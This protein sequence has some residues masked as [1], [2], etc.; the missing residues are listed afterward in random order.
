MQ[1][2]RNNN[3]TEEKET[4]L[5]QQFASKYVPYWPLFLVAIII[6]IAIAYIYLRY[7]TP[8]YQ[9]SATLII[10]DE[11][12]GNE[13]SKIVESL[14]Q[15]SSKKIVENEIEIIQSRKLMEDVIKKLGLYAP[16]YE[17]GD[18]HDVLAYTK[19]P[20]SIIALYPDSLS[21]VESINLNYNLNNQEVILDHRY[22]Y[23]IDTLVNTP[24]GKLKFVRNQYYTSDSA[25]KQFYFSLTKPKDLVPSFLEGLMV[26]PA[27]KL[28]SIVDLSYRDASP[29]RAE[30]ILNQLIDSYQQSANQEKDALAQNTLAFVNKRLA[31][32]SESLD[33][34]EKNVQ[35]FKSGN[36]AVDIS[37]QG[38]LFLQNVSTNDQKLG[39][40]TTQL[41]VLDKVDE[42]VKSNKNSKSGI[43]PSTLGVEDPML[44]QLIDKLYASELE[45]DDLSKTVGENNPR[46]VTIADKINKL[47]PSIISNINSMRQS[48]LASKKNIESTNANYNS[49]LQRVPEKEKELLDI[50][51]EQQIKTNLYAFL[52]QKKEESQIAAASSV[53]NSRV[54]DYAQSSPF[55]VSPRRNLIYIISIL[56]L[57]GLAGAFI[58]IKEFLTGKVLYRHEIESLTSIPI[59]GEIAFDKSKSNIVIEKGTRSFVAEEFR[60]LRISLSFL[61]IGPS[62]KKILVT[63][64]ISG[65]G[66]SFISANLAVSLSL[67]G[68]KVVLVDM[69]LNNPTLDKILNISREEGVTEYLDGQKDPEEIIKHV[70][71]HENLFFISAGAILPENPSELLSN[72]K[73]ADLIN[74]L[75]NI[76]DF[77]LIDTS[78]MVLV[79]DGYLLTGLCDA[80]LYVIR[81]HYTPK[82][83]IKRI[84]ENIHINPINN[85]AIIFNGVKMRGF[86]KNNYGYGYD[87]VY[88][89]KDRK[90]LEKKSTVKY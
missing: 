1:L 33:S 61:G 37:T 27:S 13:E 53:S 66:K 9:A 56:L 82:M 80:T 60:K 34:I 59:L 26:V 36:R 88:G 48:L 75:E 14:D 51:R 67:T 10:K 25:H 73:A 21:F 43:V 76:F 6:G 41:A 15:I 22:K 3:I 24:F 55:P 20:I 52:L 85:P 87:Y 8:M 44:S 79:T 11:K 28:S 64:S 46:L 23:Q 5:V 74:Y 86:F 35:E 40:L 58:F 72:G 4:N 62:H 47:K 70:A 17:K 16:I 77:V 68:K 54:V 71:D 45:Y 50:S 65:E 49:I 7:S 32:V 12:K 57:V 69:D 90:I 83:L 63:S 31:I 42:F 89:N 29:I 39:E 84:D 2:S 30:N 78:P 38:Q 81:H 19:S 18:V